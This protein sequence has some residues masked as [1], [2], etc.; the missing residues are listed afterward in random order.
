MRKIYFFGTGILLICLAA[1]G[2]YNLYKPHRNVEG[3]EAVA[4]LTATSLYN[5]FVRNESEANQKW[6]GKVL[7][8]NGIISSVTGSGNYV[9]LNLAAAAEGGVNCSVLK[10]DLPADHKFNKGDSISIKGKCTG[11]LMDVNMVDCIIKK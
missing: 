8:V 10:K 6:I 4:T 11:F 5:E 9:S 2:L 1:W 7:E 3:E